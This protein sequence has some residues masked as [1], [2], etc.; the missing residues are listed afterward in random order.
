M[1]IISWNI[2]GLGS[3]IKKWFL[4]KLI[5]KR[6]LDVV[7][8]QETKLENVDVFAIQKIWGHGEFDFACLSAIGASGGLLVIWN[9]EFFKADYVITHRSFIMLQGVIYNVFPCT[10]INIYVPNDVANRRILWEELL[11]LK[12]N[13]PTLW[14]VGGDFNEIKAITERVG[15]Q[16]LERGM[17]DFLEFCNNMELIDPPML[18]RKFTWTNYQDH[19]IHSRLDRFLI[20]P[21][22]ME[23]FKVLQCGLHKPI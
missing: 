5:K 21:Q 13:S 22:W 15:C 16:R 8:V 18:G 20:S 7:F 3:S 17:K 9:K 10:L 23:K 1:Q 19:A 11:G 2:R 14:C 6:K 12:I 4:F